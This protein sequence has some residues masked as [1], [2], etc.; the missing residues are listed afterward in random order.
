ME[1]L[2]LFAKIDKK[3]KYHIQHFTGDSV[4]LTLFYP[5]STL[6]STPILIGV[7]IKMQLPQ[8][9]EIASKKAL[10]SYR[11]LCSLFFVNDSDTLFGTASLSS[12]EIIFLS[13]QRFIM[14][15]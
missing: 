9:I 6:I 5:Y 2:I 13:L 11:T 4:S 7:D 10:F 12:T 14:Q 15:M 1:T 3:I 8:N